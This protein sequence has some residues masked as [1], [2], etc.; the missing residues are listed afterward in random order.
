MLDKNIIKQ[1]GK[2][3]PKITAVYL[4]GSKAR[5]EERK[6]SDLDIAIVVK[7]ASIKRLK[8]IFEEF[9]KKLQIPNLDLR[10]IIPEETDPLFLF[11][12]IKGKLLYFKSEKE[13]VQFETKAMKL[14]YDTQHL[15]NIYHFYLK[16]RLSKGKYGK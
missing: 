1:I 9:S 16:E 5:G 13:K 6:D 10:I 3:F 4:I 15:R 12:V 8:N 14:F 2:K 11:Q 7:K